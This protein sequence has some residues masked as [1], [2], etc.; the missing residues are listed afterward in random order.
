MFGPW[1]A[2]EI[3]DHAEFRVGR[4]VLQALGAEHP[5]CFGNRLDGWWT[6]DRDGLERVMTRLARSLPLEQTDMDAAIA[7][8]PIASKVPTR[9]L[10]ISPRSPATFHER[11]GGWVRRNA[12]NRDAAYLVLLRA[13]SPLSAQDLASAVG[14]T[15]HNVR[16]AL[17]RD[18]R[19]RAVRPGSTWSLTEWS[20]TDGP[21][22]S[23]TLEAAI[24]VLEESG[25]LDY[26]QFERRVLERYPVSPW[27]VRQCLGTEEIGRWPDG[28]V[29]LTARGAP[30][31]EDQEPR[32][33]ENVSTLGGTLTLE[34]A[35]DANL[36]R[37][38]GVPIPWYVT[39]WLGLRIAPRSTRFHQIGGSQIVVRRYKAGPAV[40]AL[41]SQA[42]Q[43][44]A[45]QGCRL[46]VS[47]TPSS[48]EATVALACECEAHHPKS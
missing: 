9:Q 7:A 2:R 44:G 45:Q 10:L 5:Q 43:L 16:A 6:C 36:L 1:E 31:V 38:S 47:L 32:R 37:G 21:S 42:E 15:A 11:V 17:A 20:S 34:V 40:S 27:S 33:P 39:W 12:Q 25:P 29:D 23:T 48:G 30:L 4:M 13:G 26:G 46:R 8:H 18:V 28:R 41:R 19:F 35:V 24:A 22:Y 3:D 14:A